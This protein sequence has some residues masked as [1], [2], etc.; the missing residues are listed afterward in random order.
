[1]VNIIYKKADAVL[2]GSHGPERA[3]HYVRQA[4]NINLR[5]IEDVANQFGVV[6]RTIR[7]WIKAGELTAHKVNRRY[8]IDDNDVGNF[9]ARRR[10]LI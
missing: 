8:W 7:N 5:S 2:P 9:L 1:M 4:A 3:G 10:G 6:P